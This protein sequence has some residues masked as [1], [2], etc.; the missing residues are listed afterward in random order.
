MWI[1]LTSDD[2]KISQADLRNIA[3]TTLRQTITGIAG[4]SNILVMGGT[5]KQYTIFLDPSRLS[6]YGIEIDALEESLSDI[7]NPGGAGVIIQSSKELPVAL[8]A[9]PP[10]IREIEDI[11][12]GRDAL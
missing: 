3:E 12:I 11:S 8:R 7:T 1:G 10:D 5:P 2:P 6:T 9:T 4:V